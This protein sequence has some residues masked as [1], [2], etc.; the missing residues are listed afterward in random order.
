MQVA[1]KY[2]LPLAASERFG[3]ASATAASSPKTRVWVFW[4]KSPG[5]HRV[6]R[7]QVAE[8]ASGCAACG[9]ELV[10]GQGLFI[11]RDPIEEQGGINLYGFCSNDGVNKYDY[12]GMFTPWD[13]GTSSTIWVNPDNDRDHEIEVTGMPI[14]SKFI[15]ATTGSTSSTK[16]VVKYQDTKG[17]IHEEVLGFADVTQVSNPG[18]FERV[19]EEWFSNRTAR[20]SDQIGG[21]SKLPIPTQGQIDSVL[22]TYGRY[23]KFQGS[24]AD[25]KQMQTLFA[26]AFLFQRPNG[27]PSIAI[28]EFTRI[29]KEYGDGWEGHFYIGFGPGNELMPDKRTVSIERT[30]S[31]GNLISDGQMV[32][33]IMHEILHAAD[34]MY[35]QSLFYWADRHNEI[36]R[37][38]NQ[39]LWDLGLPLDRGPRGKQIDE[40]N[41]YIGPKW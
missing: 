32:V 6:R 19:V 14:G 17:K 15:S 28:R 1:P 13:D 9:Y 23:F 7:S 39:T 12:L 35:E 30:G 36:Y 31:I 8:L 38:Q 20:D 21:G 2:A 3:N 27:N 18:D 5:R 29:V 22:S 26:Q 33:S 37:M 4:S 24:A 10:S 25:V 34:K 40:G 16:A 11:N 41:K